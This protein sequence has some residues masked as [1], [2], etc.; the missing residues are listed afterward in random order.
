MYVIQRGSVARFF[1]FFLFFLFRSATFDSAVWLPF[2]FQHC[3]NRS[4]V[5]VRAEMVN[6][7]FRKT[8]R[9]VLSND[10]SLR[11]SLNWSTFGWFTGVF[12]QRR[13]CVIAFDQYGNLFARWQEIFQVTLALFNFVGY[14]RKNEW[15]VFIS[16]IQTSN[17]IVDWWMIFLNDKRIIFL[18]L[19][20]IYIYICLNRE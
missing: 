13:L 3:V 11:I 4:L 14:R 10:D 5:Q 6:G 2:C 15:K 7:F 16:H 12:L 18:I 20:Y 1:F 8:R 9:V 17:K 19:K